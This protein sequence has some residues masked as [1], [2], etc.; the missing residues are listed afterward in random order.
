MYQPRGCRKLSETFAPWSLR[1]FGSQILMLP[2]L[3]SLRWLCRK[4]WAGSVELCACFH[5]TRSQLDTHLLRCY[6]PC[7]SKR[8]PWKRAVGAP[9]ARFHGSCSPEAR[10]GMW[11]GPGPLYFLSVFFSKHLVIVSVTIARDKLSTIWRL[12][13]EGLAQASVETSWRS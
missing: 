13:F 7:E 4:P 12:D 9:E 11:K 5:V 10:L 2:F 1:F 6:P 3:L 8:W